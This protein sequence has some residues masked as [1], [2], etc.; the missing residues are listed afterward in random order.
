MSRARRVA[1]A[2]TTYCSTLRFSVQLPH[3]FTRCAPPSGLYQ[4]KSPPPHATPPRHASLSRIRAS[5]ANIPCVFQDSLEFRLPRLRLY[6][7]LLDDDSRSPN[8]KACGVPKRDRISLSAY[9]VSDD[10]SK[11]FRNAQAAFVQ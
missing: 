8:R 7:A 9:N 11:D 2:Y 4:R 6:S 5:T 3:P 1:A 10:P